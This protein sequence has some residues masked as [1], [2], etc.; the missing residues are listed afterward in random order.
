MSPQSRQ[1][2]L[3]LASTSRYRAALLERL[4]IPFE[5][6]APG[7]NEDAPDGVAERELAAALAARK[8]HAVADARPE[9]WV[10]GSDQVAWRDGRRLGK[11]GDAASA[12]AQLAAS[13]GHTLRFDTAVCLRGVSAGVDT[14]VTTRTEVR[15]RDL[16]PAEIERY[17][18]ADRP[19][20][21]A[22]AFKVES[23][24]VGLF[25]WVRGDDPTALEGL[26]LITLCRLLRA[27]GFEV[28]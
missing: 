22:G 3:V 27:A 2:T 11:P 7:V 20:D 17:V 23:R 6:V 19:F 4:G 14:T 9:Q 28:P 8:A 10:I 5:V 25:E 26:P 15:F 21:C 18:A 13:S 12:R 24:G 16:A 1:S